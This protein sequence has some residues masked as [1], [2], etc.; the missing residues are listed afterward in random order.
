MRSIKKH[1]SIGKKLKRLASDHIGLFSLVWFLTPLLLVP[2]IVLVQV[3]VLCVPPV[4]PVFV[5]HRFTAT[6]AVVT[7]TVE[8]AAAATAP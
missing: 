6:A 8:A 3:L 4:L 7:A 2:I 1:E 5:T